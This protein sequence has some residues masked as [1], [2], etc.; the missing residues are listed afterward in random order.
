MS[1]T[2]NLKITEYYDED[3]YDIGSQDLTCEQE[4]ISF[5]VQNLCDC[6]EDAIIGRGLFS[7]NDYVK[8]LELGMKL[9]QMGYTDIDVVVNTEN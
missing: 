6:P 5:S 7:A 4:K 3:I 8:A 2:L 9:A 1:K